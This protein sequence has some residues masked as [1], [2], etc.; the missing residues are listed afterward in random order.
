MDIYVHISFQMVERNILISNKEVGVIKIMI[1]DSH[2]HY[3][4]H[5]YDEDREEVLLGLKDRNVAKI[6]DISADLDGI[7]KVLELADK[8]DFVYASVGVHPDEVEELTDAD[9]DYMRQQCKHSKVVAIGEIGLDYFREEEYGK[10]RDKQKEW[11]RKQLELARELDLPVIIH[12]RDA[13]EDT[14]AIMKEYSDLRYVMHCYSYTKET[15]KELLNMNCI[16][17]IGGVVTFKN[18]KKLK[19]AVEFIPVDKIILE[20]DCPYLAPDPF[21]GTRNDSGLI[22]YVIEEI[23]RIKELDPKYVEQ[24]CWENTH[25]FYGLEA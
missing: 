15:A 12:S 17:G 23:A 14:L 22:S 25:K 16:F 5:Q 8:Y 24:T 4:S 13:C 11:F 21:R 9:L 7:A 20:T 10:S 2:A 19:E 1:F 6:V 3:D 18:S